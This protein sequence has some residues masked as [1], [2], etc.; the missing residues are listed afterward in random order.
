MGRVL[1]DPRQTDGTNYNVRVFLSTTTTTTTTTTTISIN[2][3]TNPSPFPAQPERPEDR[4]NSSKMSRALIN[5]SVLTIEHGENAERV[6]SAHRV[7]RAKS[8][9][10]I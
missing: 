5:V 10:H 9:F 1:G 4:R 8:Y 7:I 3:S 6:S 2:A